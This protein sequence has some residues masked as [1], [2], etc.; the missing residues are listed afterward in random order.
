MGAFHG[1]LHPETRQLA[2]PGGDRDQPVQPPVP[3][4]TPHS[5]TERSTTGSQSLEPKDE[6]PPRHHQL[7][8]HAQEGTPEVRLRM[9][10]HH[11]VRD[12]T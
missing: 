5:F 2:E 9:K 3:R 10:Q 4:P 11:T 7:A 8:V 1:A 12:Q 6:P